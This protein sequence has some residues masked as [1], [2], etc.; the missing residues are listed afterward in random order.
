MPPIYVISPLFNAWDRTESMIFSFLKTVDPSLAHLVLVDNGSTDGTKEGLKKFVEQYPDRIRVITNEKNLGFAGGVN[1]GLTAIESLPWEGVCLLNSDVVLTANWLSRM[2]M[3]LMHSSIPNL[4]IIG[5]MS[6][7]VGGVQS[8][9]QTSYTNEATLNAF[10]AERA[11]AFSGQVASTG[12]LIGLCYLMKRQVFDK[13]GYF[14]TRFF[15]GNWE[16]NDYSLRAMSAG[17]QLGVDLSTYIHHEGSVSFIQ[18]K[19]DR[20]AAYVDN[21]KRFRAKWRSPESP[22]EQVALERYRLRKQEP[23]YLTEPGYE[24]LVKK[25][26]VAACRVKDGAWIIGKVLERIS[27][28]ADEIVVLVDQHTSDNTEE[29]VRQFPKVTHMEKEPPH[30]YNEAWSRNKVLDMARDRG[31]DWIWCFDCDE[32]P[33]P[34]IVDELPY[35]TNPADPQVCL[36]TFP[37][38]Q[39]WNSDKTWR[40]DGLWGNFLQGRMYRVLPNQRI[41]NSNNKV[42]SGSHPNFGPGSISRS[43]VRIVHYGNVDPAIR[44]KKYEWYTRTDTDGDLGMVLGNKRDYYWRMYYGQPVEGAVPEWRTIPDDDKWG[45]PRYGNFYKRDLYRHVID[46][47]GLQLIPFDE[48]TRL[49]LTM[50]VKN[51]GPQMLQRALMSVSPFIT[52]AIV[53]DTGT[54]Q[55]EDDVAEQLGAKV[56]Y[57]TWCDDFSAAR[58]FSMS[59]ARGNWIFRLDPD[60]FLP[61]D[62]GPHLIQLAQER[63]VDGYLWPI[64][65]YQEVPDGKGEGRWVLSETCRL[66]R[67][68]PGVRFE[69]LV[70]EEI[71]SSLLAIARK[72]L[73]AKG[74]VESELTEV[75]LQQELQIRRVPYFIA[76]FGYLRGQQF[77]DQKFDYYCSLGEQQIL[78]KPEEGAAYFNTAVHYYHVGDMEKALSRY[79]EAVKRSPQNFMALSDIGAVHF[80][81]GN[82]HEARQWFK[83]ALKAA[84]PTVHPLQRQKIEQNLQAVQIR[85]M[86][87]LLQ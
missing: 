18:A 82:L 58:N 25:Y 50:L 87:L 23:V 31:A 64:R 14:D 76:H 47:R 79:H 12:V 48:T 29:I 32:M 28:F 37:I 60:E 52:E 44:Q 71:D 56:H 81:L 51:E 40:Q 77:L 63:G 75:Q 30:E 33:G 62:F 72:R 69:G 17:F 7:Q 11:Q 36:W 4:G 83:K 15:P 34:E 45:I 9:G 26:V 3:H 80:Q 2:W 73:V 20:R 39:L 59:K 13:I 5:P 38:V 84:G 21:K 61:Q 86:E 35:L 49:S 68:Q 22:W 27:Q 42:H 57:F 74:A 67:N 43:F 53:V 55:G 65:N 16:D 6:N 66:Y 85:A 46:E 41:N 10:A 54:S 78:K 19:V 1:T 70:H 8:V 24:G